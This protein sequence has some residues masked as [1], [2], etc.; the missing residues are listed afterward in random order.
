[1]LDY[2]KK[3]S[4]KQKSINKQYS[5]HSI[6]VEIV[7]Q[8]T[9]ILDLDSVL[10]GV[11]KHVPE[12]LLNNVDIIYVANIKSFLK[13]NRSFNAMYKDGAIYISPD[14]DDEEDLIDDIIHEIAHSLEKE[15]PDEIYGDDTLE[16]EFLA[17]RRT[18]YY[19]IDKPTMTMLQYNNA[20]YSAK[21]DD[22][23]YHDVG[24]DYLRNLSSGLFYSPYAITSLREY[25]ANGFENYLLGDKQRL[26]DLSPVLYYKVEQILEPQEEQEK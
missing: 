16:R 8:F 25:W 7:H 21:F 22:H 11:E 13:Q 10:H 4:Q 14:Q 19:L 1:M 24:Y 17:K 6:P 12:R 9:N 3:S 15:Y 23:M 18:L 20:G 5:L 2:I 26:K